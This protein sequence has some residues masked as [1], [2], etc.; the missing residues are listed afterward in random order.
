MKKNFY[1]RIFASLAVL[2]F[3]TVALRAQSPGGVSGLVMW[4]KAND[5]I[6]TSPGATAQWNDVSGN[7][8]NVV[9]ENEAKKPQLVTAGTYTA[10]SRDYFFNFN[11][12]YYFDG[13]NDFFERTGALG[14]YFPNA[15]ATKAGS[16]FGTMYNSGAGGW[17]TAYG[18]GDDDPN[19]AKNGDQYEFWR[20]NGLPLTTGNIGLN[21]KPA[22]IGS[23]IWKGTGEA[24]NGLYIN[25]NGR[26]FSNASANI[27]S[28]TDDLFRIGSEGYSTGNE[29]YQG[30]ISEVFA[31]SREL[32]ANERARV[33]SYLAIK[34]GITLM[35]DAGNAT[36]DYLASN[37]TVVWSAA[38]NT[39][40][41]SNV[42]GVARD[43]GSALH[44]KV[45]K[46]ANTGNIL[47]VA[48]DGDF[49]SP[50]L[51]GS[52][53]A[54]DDQT[55]FMLGDN[56]ATGTTL[57]DITVGSL[58]LKR[59]ER[60]WLA[61]R[62]GAAGDIHFGA[63]LQSYGS[64]FSPLNKVYMIIA[65][66]NAFT[67]NVRTVS[68]TSIGG[69]W[70]S[71]YDFDGENS[72]QYITYGYKEEPC[73]PTFVWSGPATTS[74]MTAT[75]TI[76][77]IGYTFTSNA[78]V[79]TTNG[80][81]NGFGSIT[82]AVISQFSNIPMTQAGVIMN[83][84]ANEHNTLT[85]DSP[86]TD[87]VLLFS[88]LGNV[89]QEV[90]VTFTSPDVDIQVLW[91]AAVAGNPNTYV[92]IG[93]RTI[94]AKEGYAI[95]R[96][97]GTHT[98]ISFDYIPGESYANFL[99]G[100][101]MEG[102]CSTPTCPTSINADIAPGGVT[103]GLSYWY[104]ADMNVS[105]T[106]EGT[107]VTAWEDMWGGT[108]SG[109]VGANTNL[110][111]YKKGTADYFNF[112]AG[113]NFTNTN[114]ALGNISV[115][116]LFNLNYDIFTLTKEGLAGTRFLN[117]GM[118]NTTANGTNWDQ[119][120]FYADGLI[121]RRTN[122]GAGNYFANP[123]GINFASATPSIMYHTFSNTTLSKGL[124]GAAN[125]T[126]A[127]HTAIN[128]V[129]GGHI[130]GRN[131]NVSGGGLPGGDDDGFIGN[132]GETI[133]YGCGNL[134]ATERRRVDTYLGIKYGITLGRTETDHY[135]AADE[136]IVWDG[137]TNTVY[138]NNIFG[139]AREDIEAFNQK[140]SK[141][142]NAGT[143][144]TIAT[145]SDFV[146][147][148]DEAGRRD[149]DN[150]KTYFI[151][152]D[153]NNT[154]TSL[155]DITVGSLD[156]KRIQKDW[157]SQR[158]GS[159]EDMHFSTDL[160]GYGVNFNG[161]NSVY[162]IIADDAAFT[163]NVRTVAATLTNGEWVTAYDFDSQNSIQY[164][165][166]GYAPPVCADGAGMKPGGIATA[167]WY[168]ADALVYSDAGTTL[169]GD[170]N[171]VAQWNEFNGKNYNLKQTTSANRPVFSNSTTLSNFNPTV[172]FTGSSNTRLDY[173]V[174]DNGEILDRNTG[175][176]FSAGKTSANAGLF[177][178][179]DNMDYPGIYI[180]GGDDF[181][182]LG[183]FGGN[184][185][186][187]V[188]TPPNAQG[189]FIGGGGWLNGAGLGGLNLVA[190]SY[191][192]NYVSYDALSTWNTNVAGS[193]GNLSVG[194]DPNWANLTGQQNEMMIFCNK[195]SD[196]QMNRVESYLAIKYGQTLSREN[197]R[198][199]LAS[200]GSIIWNGTANQDHYYNV[201]GLGRQ[202][203]AAF[204]QRVSKSVNTGAIMT[205]AAD[206]D[207]VL[208]NADGTRRDFDE[209]ET[210][211]LLGDNNNTATTFA[212]ITVGSLQ[213]QRIQK[214]WLSQR[215]GSTETLHF[216]TNLSGY[217]VNFDGGNSVYMIIADD[218]AF[219]TNV[220]TVPATLVN[221]EWVSNYNFDGQVANQYISYGF[222][223]EPQV[224][225]CTAFD[226]QKITNGTFNGNANGW[227]VS[228]GGWTYSAGEMQDTH[229][230]ASN[231]ILWQEMS[232]ITSQTYKLSFK[233]GST[234]MNNTD[235]SKTAS[236]EVKIGGITYA[237]INNGTGTNNNVTLTLAN[238]A[239]IAPEMDPSAYPYSSG[240]A[241]INRDLILLIPHNAANATPGIENQIHFV[242][243]ANG[244]DFYLD[245][246][247]LLGCKAPAPAFTCNDSKL[248]YS[249]TESGTTTLYDVAYAANPFTRTP[250][251]STTNIAYNAMGYNT[252]DGFVYAVRSEAG[253]N[254][255]HLVKIGAN[256]V[257][258]DLGAVSGLPT[259]SPGAYVSGDFDNAG[260]LYVSNEGA[261]NIY[262]IN[263][264]S[265][266]ATAV[267]L[268][269]Q[270]S[271]SDIAYHNG[272]F[273]GVR[274][275]NSQ[276]V[277][278]DPTS[279]TVTNIGST[280]YGTGVFGAMMGACDGVYGIAN[281]GGYYKF[282]LVT[283]ARTKLAN[284]PMA[285][286]GVD[287]AHCHTACIELPELLTVT[288]NVFEDNTDDNTVNGTGTN[289]YDALYV[290]LVQ[291]IDGIET[292]VDKVPV[293]ITGG[294][295]FTNLVAGETYK[296]MLTDE[297]SL[298]VGQTNPTPTVPADYNATGEHVGSD[299][300]N[301]GAADGILSL[302]TVTADISEANFGIKLKPTEL[303]DPVPDLGCSDSDLIDH[304]TNGGFNGSGNWNT[305]GEPG[306]WTFA[307]GEAYN[308]HQSAVNQ[309]L[310]QNMTTPLVT[311]MY[312]L[313]FKLGTT[314]QDN[315]NHTKTASLEIKIGGI[316]YATF[317]NATGTS[318][319]V[320]LTL[321]N[322]AVSGFT[323]Y[324]SGNSRIDRNVT[325]YIPHDVA[326]AVAGIEN[327]LDFIFNANGDDFYLDNVSL[328]GC[329]ETIG[330]NTSQ[331]LYSHGSPNTTIDDVNY[332]TAPLTA[333]ALGTA[334]L[335]YNAMGYNSVDGYV[336]AISDNYH[337]VRVDKR[338]AAIDL[339]TVSGLPSDYEFN[340]GD[341]IP[342]SGKL[343][344][345][346]NQT[347]KM[348][349]INVAT[350]TATTINLSS[351]APVS[352]I[353]W[354]ITTE[355]F[356]GVNN[357]T[358]ALMS[359]DPGTGS[360]TS[361]GGTG[362]GIFGAMMGA[363][364]GIY[365]ISN[366]GSFYKFNVTT[367][368][369]TYLTKFNTA[370]GTSGFDGAHCHS[371]CIN[372][373]ALPITLIRFEVYKKDKAAQL[374]WTTASEIDNKGFEVEH[375]TEGKNWTSIGFVRSKSENGLSNAKLNYTFIDNTPDNGQNLYRLKALGTDGR[376]EFSAI[377]TVNFDIV[378]NFFIYPNPTTDQVNIA[379]LQGN[380]VVKVYDFSGK[381]VLETKTNKEIMNIRFG[382]FAQGAYQISII[383]ADGNIASYKI[384]KQ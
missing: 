169:A 153:N 199:Y 103:N 148:N 243:N 25:F 62:T 310:W 78:N 201:F 68:C 178:F 247:S 134:T 229:N 381:L 205:V 226:D 361:I 43:N 149:F 120:G 204:D 353:A 124:N 273:Y 230:S 175:T 10:N 128:E 139:V 64:E 144:M 129:T 46:S 95:V 11:P 271:L 114:Q 363:C 138:N 83:N 372:D 184:W 297:T 73:P 142:V 30:G 357:T 347:K 182:F 80:V 60:A 71:E 219:T 55:F 244:D 108:S 373:E 342:G 290:A 223:P 272:L 300:G 35:N 15:D 185:A 343:Y 337:L 227:N 122:T 93:A 295:T 280:S 322:G 284:T 115:Q 37:S 24:N 91:Q 84:T 160:S 203:V 275:S 301:D 191:N 266:T 254:T 304:V 29:Y 42:F 158:T 171:G 141:S 44:Q 286:T 186:T 3:T 225:P 319:N 228:G 345:A 133:I 314:E 216:S 377:R 132:I 193:D 380:E 77:G 212:D 100:F 369:R 305:T 379:G 383:S 248:L 99:F 283:G 86:I 368:A 217:G 356:Y 241:R 321:A 143:I 2:L 165:T 104:R 163:T 242:F 82:P 299:S 209:D 48:T 198:N 235:H 135:L 67:T 125:G 41:N 117:I 207:F 107:D 112:N 177:G 109:Q 260:N 210:Y 303:P 76:G 152:G 330:C 211:F 200:D 161:G 51:D 311:Q 276:L 333:T 85:F 327:Q 157:L 366:N 192:G 234:E 249:G 317:N 335:K 183:S 87:P 269:Q 176:L 218:P 364:N 26:M 316:T 352:D 341:F 302:G 14:D 75:G 146:N 291:T 17:N 170:G 118:D 13:S 307:G 137:S 258:T 101:S 375:S 259:S 359:L 331:M 190:T 131:A 231:Q 65:D 150:N 281:N 237:T 308:Q 140:A 38:T 4:H 32:T 292:V 23:I 282:D 285:L 31:Y 224:E 202:D 59:I 326:N 168:R 50:N 332:S 239:T 221:G 16:V 348:Y 74:G 220:R 154:A 21:T 123:G 289:V 19:L 349:E 188:N 195:L 20:D 94:T 293:T 263:V 236:L 197:N 34:N 232:A 164:I 121:A 8:K 318:N 358:G 323:S 378:S 340:S 384:I 262:K 70:V 39:A 113:V 36:A 155:V 52:R 351:N 72:N 261:T 22:H 56:G 40:F 159:A 28:I 105:N 162:M 196:A 96:I 329:E 294:Y 370:P 127:S 250:L 344:V 253:A 320:T 172:T 57:T 18:W 339:G 264:A 111:K 47:T 252:Q 98:S 374:V 61:Q 136:S 106:G 179:G 214:D 53:T 315:T 267:T 334:S 371:N 151:L 296:V 278:I 69:K 90:V 257:S 312:K 336:Y 89:G 63:N 233:L 33:N 6:N 265:M 27:G 213:L 240:N 270:V 325:I 187:D 256:G 298:S 126:T 309:K 130:F 45:S 156:L 5:G 166:Y 328:L 268:S 119:P 174:S 66:D 355:K 116:T 147:P 255:N 97:L 167:A 287:G 215:T 81:F 324:S 102:D 338:G 354:D 7:N 58:N 9:Q 1:T 180:T 365:G 208:P 88:S 206:G 145:T 110:P 54:L 222:N 79:V 12:F 367:G 350:R 49:T 238:G 279:G 362:G 92:N 277:S 360:V 382:T 306:G 288:G 189:N 346:Q 245:N 194:R 246:I 313:S 173:L 181:T 251:G 274:N 376:F